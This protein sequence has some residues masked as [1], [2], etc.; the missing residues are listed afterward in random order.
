MVT[1]AVTAC[2]VL[3]YEGKDGRQVETNS[4][5]TMQLFLRADVWKLYSILDEHDMLGVFDI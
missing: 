2:T 1:T 3:F 4:P 5:P